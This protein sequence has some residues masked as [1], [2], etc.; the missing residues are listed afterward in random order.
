MLQKFIHK[1]RLSITLS[2]LRFK[3]RKNMT[4]ETENNLISS[5][6]EYLIIKPE[7]WVA[8]NGHRIYCG[9]LRM[10]SFKNKKFE[11]W[12]H[13]VFDILH[14]QDIKLLRTKLLGKDEI[15]KIN[16]EINNDFM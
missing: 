8:K 14:S 11:K 12:I 9:D 16:E 5:F 4:Q 2:Y 7:L 1:V 6:S 13:Q 3:N 10:Y 15:E